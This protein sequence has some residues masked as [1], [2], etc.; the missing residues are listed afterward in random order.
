LACIFAPSVGLF[1]PKSFERR[2]QIRYWQRI[3]IWRPLAEQ[4][5]VRIG[6]P[7]SIFLVSSLHNSSSHFSANTLRASGGRGRIRFLRTTYWL[8]EFNRSGMLTSIGVMSAVVD[9]ISAG[10][11]IVLIA[12][13]RAV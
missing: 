6:D 8:S 5:D 12:I 4:A 7:P 3:E 13:H 9:V 11:D 2:D 1:C 10:M